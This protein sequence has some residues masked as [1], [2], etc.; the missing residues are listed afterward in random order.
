MI[1][2]GS[3]S[4]SWL[5]LLGGGWFSSEW[6]FLVQNQR[7]PRDRRLFHWRYRCPAGSICCT[8][9]EY[10]VALSAGTLWVFLA[11]SFFFFFSGVMGALYLGLLFLPS[12][13]TGGRAASGAC[14]RWLSSSS[15]LLCF[16]RTGFPERRSLAVCCGGGLLGALLMI[17]EPVQLFQLLDSTPNDPALSVR[18]SPP[19]VLSG[20]PPTARGTISACFY[21]GGHPWLSPAD[22]TTSWLTTL[23]GG[24][25]WPWIVSSLGVTTRAFSQATIVAVTASSSAPAGAGCWSRGA[26]TR[27]TIMAT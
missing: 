5:V 10:V 11:G 27:L 3:S 14:R 18:C 1:R 7:L 4:T 15:S 6:A 19:P 23:V 21:G 13:I 8:G 25:C 17:I 2:R 26:R 24:C 16:Y 22:G 20:D 12:Y 9:H